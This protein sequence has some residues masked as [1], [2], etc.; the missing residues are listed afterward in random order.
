MPRPRTVALA[1]ALAAAAPAALAATPAAAANGRIAFSAAGNLVLQPE[2]GAATV[3][4][5]RQASIVG[6]SRSGRL[7]AYSSGL[8]GDVTITDARGRI[9]DQMNFRGIVVHSLDISP[10]GK[11]LALTAFRDAEPGATNLFPYIARITGKHLTRVK[12]RVRHTFDLRFTRDGGSFVY[13][14]APSTGDFTT[15][16][17]LRR[18]RTD[19]AR[20]VSL[21]EATG[22]AT[23]CV[24]NVSLSPGGSTAAFTG[25]PAPGQPLPPGVAVRSGVYRVSLSG[26]GRPKLVQPG[27]F[28]TAWA[29]AGD[30]IAFSAPGG[31]FRISQFGGP[32][33]QVSKL[34]TFSMT[35]LKQTA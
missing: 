15:C 4:R 12:T 30:Q 8:D 6:S 18:V 34:P 14:G 9:K 21:Y 10:N 11:L 17:S 3:V 13:A 1:L 24:V 2:K 22:G 23:P 16:A 31:T 5:G 33:T 32:V 35:W 27:A 26:R 20:D 28:A 7:L 29:P 25:D 19:G